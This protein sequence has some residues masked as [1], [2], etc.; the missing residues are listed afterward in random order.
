MKQT[1]LLCHALYL[2]IRLPYIKYMDVFYYSELC[3][4]IQCEAVTLE[5]HSQICIAFH[6]K[7]SAFWPLRLSGME[8]LYLLIYIKPNWKRGDNKV[9]TLLITS[10]KLRFHKPSPHCLIRI[11]SNIHR[12]FENSDFMFSSWDPF[13]R[14][15]NEKLDVGLSSSYNILCICL[16]HTKN[17]HWFFYPSEMLSPFYCVTLFTRATQTRGYF[18]EVW[19]CTACGIHVNGVNVV[20]MSEV[21]TS[22]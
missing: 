8:V 3:N 18:E 13:S 11:I 17:P 16:K 14:N 5:M 19:H 10:W 20:S 4:V 12:M 15:T 21:R 6:F 7:F 9:D 22:F 1:H 2:L